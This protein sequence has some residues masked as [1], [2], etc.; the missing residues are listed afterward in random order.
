MNL[1]RKLINILPD[2]FYLKIL[3]KR[4][5]GK[6]L[7]LK[8]PKT[9]NEKLQWLKLYDRKQEYVKMVD[10]Y[11]AKKYV[12]SLIGDEYIIPTLGVWNSFD[13]INFDS[14][15]N[16]FVLKC[17]HDS[18]GVIIVKDKDSLDKKFVREKINSS[19]ATDYYKLGREW[20]YKNVNRRIIAEK[21]IEF[22]TKCLINKENLE[23]DLNSEL[24]DYK[25]MCFNGKVKCVFVCSESFSGNG[26]KVTFYDREWNRMPFERHYPSSQKNIKNTYTLNFQ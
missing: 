19:L 2:R 11:E 13:E 8:S 6:S 7:N 23:N 9:F 3:Y 4:K 18:G 20:P 24:M 14:L 22:D 25:Y 26:L 17:T 16:Q 12:A 21:Y 15:P 10:K 5:M 1:K